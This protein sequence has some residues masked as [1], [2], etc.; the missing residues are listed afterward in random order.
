[1]IN[2]K[3]LPMISLTFFPIYSGSIALERDALKR[4]GDSYGSLLF[5]QAQRPFNDSPKKK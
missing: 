2:G 4:T 1:M 5:F 3:W